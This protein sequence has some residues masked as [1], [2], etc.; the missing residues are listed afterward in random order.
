MTNEAML[1]TSDAVPD[2]KPFTERSDPGH[3]LAV[4]RCKSTTGSACHFTSKI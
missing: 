4:P 2:Y 1:G 3:F